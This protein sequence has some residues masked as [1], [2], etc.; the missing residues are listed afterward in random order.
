M[1]KPNLFDYRGGRVHIIGICGA[2]LCGVA[3]MLL[4]E[5]FS[6]TGSDMKETIF[7]PHVKSLGVPFTIGHSVANVEGADFVIHSAA[8]PETNVE[9][10]YAREQGIPVLERSEAVGQFLDTYENSISVTGCHGK[11]TISSLLGLMLLKGG[12][13]PTIHVGGVLDYLGSSGTRVGDG[14]IMVLESC[15]YMNSFYNFRPRF[16]VLNN[17]DDDH[18]DFFKDMEDVYHSFE[19][20]VKNVHPDGIL[21]GCIDDPRVVKLLENSDRTTIT[22]GLSGGDYTAKDLEFDA[23]GCAAFTPVH[24]G[25]ELPR[26]KIHL[27]GDYNVANALGA[28]A[29]ARHLGCP[30]EAISEALEEYHAAE[31]R[32]EFHGELDG[33]RVY[34][35]FAHH[36]SAVK[37]CMKAASMFEYNK[38]WAVFQCNSYSRAYKLFDRFVEAFDPADTTII[39]E[40][41]PGREQDTGLVHGQQMADAI[42]ARGGDGIYIAD[43][44]DI[45]KYLQAHWQ[46]GDMVLMVG[47][48]NINEHVYKILEKY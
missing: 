25:E 35:D 45:G 47:S 39:A 2:S 48:G 31:R 33:V 12:L 38:L 23:V 41:F 7:T 11:T 17:V 14:N 24:N 20:F 19:T 5:G 27:P 10:A 36:P 18:L 8:V 21:F 46:P 30:Y 15:E 22:F 1:Q 44:V 29:V 4:K 26:V 32:F 3:D 34:H 43:F 42:T 37:A 40:I 9:L 16:A 28:M 6:V 13:D